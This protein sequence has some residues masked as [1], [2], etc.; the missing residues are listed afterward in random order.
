M[1]EFDQIDETIIKLLRRDSRI[2][3]ADLA[4]KVGLSASSC[5]RRVRALEETG[6]IRRYSIEISDRAYGRNF[7]AIVHIKLARHDPDSLQEF[8]REIQIRDEIR[9]CYA[10]SGKADYHLHVVCSDLDAY[11][12]FLENVLFRIQAVTS[13]QTNLIL[14]TLKD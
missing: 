3:N 9:A 1:T 5:W 2:S 4:E 10:T 11:N 8:V 6:V 14:R 12:R 13:V 7:A